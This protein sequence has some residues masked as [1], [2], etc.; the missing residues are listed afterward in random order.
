MPIRPA[1]ADDDLKVAR[2]ATTCGLT[3][4]PSAERQLNHSRLFVKTTNDTDI[5]GFALVWILGSEAELIDLGVEPQLRRHGVGR[6]LLSFVLNYVQE[7]GATAV[8]LEVRAGNRAARQLYEALQFQVC[9][10]RERYYSDGEDAV[11][12]RCCIAA[13]V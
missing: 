10:H 11:L 3:V 4:N 12:Y 2:L 9:G 5:C 13:P 8:F 6:E 7:S 1:G